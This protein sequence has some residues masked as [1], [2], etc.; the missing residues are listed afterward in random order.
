[1]N[2][3]TPFTKQELITELRDV[4]FAFSRELGRIY[5]PENAPRL[6]G[7]TKEVCA[8]SSDMDDSLRVQVNI[9]NFDITGYMS[10]LYDYGILG[11][12]HAELRDDWEIVQEDIKGF[13]DGLRD[14][15]LLA[16]NA[17]DYSL[18][19]CLQVIELSGLRLAIDEGGYSTLDDGSMLWGHMALKDLAYLASIDEKTIRNLA[20]PKAKNSLRTVKHGSRTFVEIEVARDWLRQRGFKETEVRSRN[21]ERDISNNSFL[22]PA[23]LGAYVRAKRESLQLTIEDMVAEMNGSNQEERVRQL[24]LGELHFELAFFAD[25][26]RVL[27]MNVREFVVAVLQLHQREEVAKVERELDQAAKSSDWGSW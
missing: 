4:L 12:L 5:L 7:F 9:D 25:L 17:D 11:V 21:A 6:M 18:D 22:S 3:N 15:P 8:R 16:N 13:F 14:F 26:A 20:N 27:Q 23:D 10:D 24:E 1:M 2:K 19:K